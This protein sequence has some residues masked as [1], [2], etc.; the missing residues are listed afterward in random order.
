[1]AANRFAKQVVKLVNAERSKAGLSSLSLNTELTQAAE[2][3]STDMAIHD[4]FSHT[5]LN[6]SSPFDR[7]RSS[8]YEYQVASENIAAGFSTPKA[9]VQSWMNSSGHRANMLNPNIQNIGVGYFYLAQDTGNV[10]YHNYWTLT[11]GEPRPSTA[12]TSAS[13]AAAA[14][15][16]ELSQAGNPTDDL[17][18]DPLGVNPLQAQGSDEILQGGAG[19]R[20]LNP[21]TSQDSLALTRSQGLDL[22]R[23]F[24]IGQEQLT[25]ATGLNLESIT[26][27][28]GSRAHSND[29]LLGLQGSN[30]ALPFLSG[31]PVD[32]LRS[33]Q[34]EG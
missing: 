14:A 7:I 25:L 31:I 10:N 33:G 26:A 17:I 18:H 20:F 16:A 27:S 2:K 28:Q 5:G 11:F 13:F 21:G 9:V 3:H 29:I 15:T 12:R 22:S 6:G 24:V 1:M 23:D 34:V 30:E 19:D 32:S 4:Y 8:G